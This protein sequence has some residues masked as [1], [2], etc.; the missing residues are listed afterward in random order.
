MADPAVGFRK[1]LS[2]PCSVEQELRTCLTRQPGYTSGV[3]LSGQG[4]QL[5]VISREEVRALDLPRTGEVTIGRD[6]ASTVRID[7]EK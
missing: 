3:A 6:E 4:Y 7:D 5:V 2:H 1:S